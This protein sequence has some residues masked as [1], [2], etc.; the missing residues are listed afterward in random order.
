MHVAGCSSKDTKP[1]Q[2][3]RCLGIILKL[4]IPRLLLLNTNIIWEVQVTG[5]RYNVKSREGKVF[6]EKGGLHEGEGWDMYK[7]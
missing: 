4:S 7:A 3:I 2:V 6:V 1:P 5:T